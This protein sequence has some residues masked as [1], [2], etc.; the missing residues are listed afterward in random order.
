MPIRKRAVYID[1]LM[2]GLFI[3]RRDDSL[4]EEVY[5]IRSSDVTVLVRANRERERARFPRYSHD[6]QSQRQSFRAV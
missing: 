3:L 5:K 2:P 6:F 4:V 1:S